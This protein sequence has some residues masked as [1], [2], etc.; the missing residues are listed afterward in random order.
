MTTTK[1]AKTAIITLPNCNI[2]AGEYGAS[3]GHNRTHEDAFFSR[4][5]V[6]KTM[7]VATAHTQNKTIITIIYTGKLGKRN[8]EEIE[9]FYNKGFLLDLVY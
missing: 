8:L 7:Q 9:G 1:T 2:Q 5:K 3:Y 6:S 4:F